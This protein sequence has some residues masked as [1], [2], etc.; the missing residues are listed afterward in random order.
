MEGAVFD[1][2][3]GAPRGNPIWLQSAVGLSKTRERMEEIAAAIP[4]RYF[5]SSNRNALTNC[6]DHEPRI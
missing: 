5:L 3:S 6:R 2:F 4:G 1:I